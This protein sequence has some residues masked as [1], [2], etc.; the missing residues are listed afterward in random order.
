MTA[1]E[2]LIQ[3]R[4]PGDLS[5]QPQGRLDLSAVLQRFPEDARL[6]RRLV[7]ENPTFRELCDDYALARATLDTLNGASAS[8]RQAE[9][10]AD[11]VSFVEE[12]DQE[13]SELLENARFTRC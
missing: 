7:L 3:T 5:M 11:Y 8:V 2:F 13:L 12:L 4:T 9:K 6:I 1:P 10:I